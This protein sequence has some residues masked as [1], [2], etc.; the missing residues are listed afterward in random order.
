[1]LDITKVGKCNNE[2]AGVVK[3]A[4]KEILDTLGPI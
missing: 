2:N 1:M 4:K 3:R